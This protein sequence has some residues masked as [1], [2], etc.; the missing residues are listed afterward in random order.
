MKYLT[1]TETTTLVQLSRARVEQLLREG[2]FPKPLQHKVH[3]KRLW[4]RGELQTWLEH[5][6][7]PV[8]ADQITKAEVAA[9]LRVTR[10]RI[11]QLMRDDATFPRH[12][13]TAGR[14]KLWRRRDV[15]NW[16]RGEKS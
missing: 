13:A 2:R 3:S 11:Q 12:V 7:A 4:D 15:E 6:N 14:A 16:I 5:R 10:G 8:S 1:M 9:L